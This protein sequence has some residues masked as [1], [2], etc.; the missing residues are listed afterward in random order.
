MDSDLAQYTRTFSTASMELVIE[1]VL[2]LSSH[3]QVLGPYVV[4]RRIRISLL[5]NS[6]WSDQPVVGRV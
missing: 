1:C 6:P 2:V 5:P 3:L 4:A